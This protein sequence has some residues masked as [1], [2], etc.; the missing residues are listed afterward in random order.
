MHCKSYSSLEQSLMFR[1]LNKYLSKRWNSLMNSN[2][3]NR[4][5]TFSS[6]SERIEEACQQGILQSNAWSKSLSSFSKSNHKIYR[7]AVVDDNHLSIMVSHQP[8][9]RYLTVR[10]EQPS[11][12]MTHHLKIDTSLMLQIFSGAQQVFLIFQQL[13][14]CHLIQQVN[15]NHSKICRLIK[16]QLKN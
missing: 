4:L 5:Q 11:L 10:C 2:Q 3:S 14:R 13:I 12:T 16:E 1:S 8:I 9:K 15:R 7:E 6:L